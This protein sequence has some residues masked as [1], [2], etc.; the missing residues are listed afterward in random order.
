[1]ARFEQEFWNPLLTKDHLDEQPLTEKLYHAYVL[2]ESKR[3]IPCKRCHKQIRAMNHRCPAANTTATIYNT[4][5][6]KAQNAILFQKLLP[7]SSLYKLCPYGKY[8]FTSKQC[9]SHLPLS[10]KYRIYNYKLFEKIPIPQNFTFAQYDEPIKMTPIEILE[11]YCM[12]V[13][14]DM[15]VLP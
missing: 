1:M 12:H 11:D 8:R 5:H 4:K 3:A 2:C 10:K 9:I 6:L 7:H 15:R 14:K 13:P